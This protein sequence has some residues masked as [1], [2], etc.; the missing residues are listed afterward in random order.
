M[1]Y[2]KIT[3]KDLRKSYPVKESSSESSE[4]TKP[5]A[6]IKTVLDIAELDFPAGKFIAIMGLSGSG[7]STLM[8]MLGRL[9]HPDEETENT[10]SFVDRRALKV[11]YQKKASE[12]GSDHL[13]RKEYFGFVFQRCYEFKQFSS[14]ENVILPLAVRGLTTSKRDEVG[15]NLMKQLGIGDLEDVK[16][17]GLSGGQISRV[18]ILRGI[19][20]DPEIVFADEPT[21]SLDPETG[22]EVMKLLLDWQRAG[23]K[24]EID[25]PRTLIMVTH[26]RT[27]AL[28]YADQIIVLKDG[29]VEANVSK[30]GDWTEE[31]RQEV[32]DNLK[33]EKKE[34]TEFKHVDLY[35]ESAWNKWF[36]LNKFIVYFAQHD[37]FPS[38][39]LKGLAPTFLGV[40][41]LWFLLLIGFFFTDLTHLG[42]IT[43]RLILKDPF[44]LKIDASVRGAESGFSA[45]MKE[46]I[47]GLQPADLRKYLNKKIETAGQELATIKNKNSDFY[48]GQKKELEQ[49]K[50]MK[51]LLEKAEA[52][53]NMVTIFPYFYASAH[54]RMANGLDAPAPSQGRTLENWADPMIRKLTFLTEKPQFLK[55]NPDN[56]SLFQEG[57]LVRKDLID[58]FDF[59]TE[60]IKTIPY[61]YDEQKDVV[62]IPVLGVVKGLPED[63]TF[64]TLRDFQWKLINRCYQDK[65]SYI[66]VRIGPL[67]SGDIPKKIQDYA[68][69]GDYYIKIV[70]IAM[71]TG[72]ESWIHWAFNDES[73]LTLQYWKE[74]LEEILPP[75]FKV[76]PVEEWTP[77]CGENKISFDRAAIYARDKN[78]VPGLIEFFDDGIPGKYELAILNHQKDA[79]LLSERSSQTLQALFSIVIVAIT[80]L[81]GTMIFSTFSGSIERRS[82]EIAVIQATGASKRMIAG[83]FLVETLIV[84]SLAALLGLGI[85]ALVFNL[86]DYSNFGFQIPENI[87]REIVDQAYA[88]M[89]FWPKRTLLFAGGLLL[90]GIVTVLTVYLFL[91]RPIAEAVKEQ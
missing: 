31:Q 33:I 41:S 7:K 70:K 59:D 35:E 66:S 61:K 52:N 21:S 55:P 54:F 6:K 77:D 91:K 10:L 67:L 5:K 22:H 46:F 15:K 25:D 42:I 36:N 64:L 4:K 44:L 11:S 39:S 83:I 71:D 43:N 73:P 56:D 23:E 24:P 51:K 27:L 34:E 20:H 85:D 78:Y 57:V 69:D 89:V 90:S 1:A 74:D 30:E 65:K 84:F 86:N 79:I 9:D 87:P 50:E 40:F 18:S 75:G 45:S 63:V 68:D 8:N 72:E 12:L 2:N 76:M 37:L 19:A 32:L 38:L 58:E 80:I 62:N 60:K 88:D 28:D 16:A 13:F 14:K 29:K 17:G 53:E 3:V 81:G 47:E 26:S 48:K 82:S 49:F